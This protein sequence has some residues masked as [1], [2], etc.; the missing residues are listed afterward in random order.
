M[1]RFSEV[2][3]KKKKLDHNVVIPQIV[4]LINIDYRKKYNGKKNEECGY[5]AALLLQI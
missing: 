5:I 2:F 1:K 4:A 3:D